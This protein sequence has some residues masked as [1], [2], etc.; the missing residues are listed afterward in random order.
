M[1]KKTK[2]AAR[3][4]LQKPNTKTTARRGLNSNPR[5]RGKVGFDFGK[6]S[7]PK[8]GAPQDDRTLNPDGPRCDLVRPA[9]NGSTGTVVRLHPCLDIN[10]EDADVFAHGRVD[11]RDWQMSDWIRG[12]RAVKYVGIDQKVTFLLMD[13]EKEQAG[14]HVWT[15]NPYKILNDAV[16]QALKAE[17]AMLG[18]RDVMARSWPN[19]VNKDSKK[20]AFNATT[21]LYFAQCSIYQHNGTVYVKDGI[22]PRGLRDDDI[23]QILELSKSGGE[24]LITALD[25]RHEDFNG[26]AEDFDQFIYPNPVDLAS[27]PFI[28]IYNPDKHK[29]VEVVMGAAEDTIEESDGPEEEEYDESKDRARKKKGGSKE[30]IGW[31]IHIEDQFLYSN[32]KKIR[33][34]KVDLTKWESTLRDRLVWWDNVLWVPSF[35][36]QAKM[37]AAAFRSCPD[38]LYYGW[39]DNEEFFTDEVK[40]IL[41]ARTSGPGAEVP[42][43]DDDDNDDEVVG[44][45]ATGRRTSAGVPDIDDDL[46]EEDEDEYAEEAVVAAVEESE[47]EGDPVADEQALDAAMDRAKNRGAK[48]KSAK[49]ADGESQTV[50]RKKKGAKKKRQAV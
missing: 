45:V 2:T 23:T 31:K 27:G 32:D 5:P 13:P 10:I 11:C 34:G 1:A 41:Q 42:G 7:R 40:G 39:K 6:N 33:R 25:S 37:L 3:P 28:T 17:S 22:P 8:T 47:D 20:K 16:H 21:W 9:W 26:D 44:T 24:E 48:K 38:L 19:L 36:E 30:M 18:N 14:E 29:A 12:Y 50:P 4:A 46:P 43:D 49:K 15:N 35:E